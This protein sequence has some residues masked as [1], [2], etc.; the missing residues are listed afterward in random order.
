[1]K[2]NRVIMIPAPPRANWMGIDANPATP[3]SCRLARILALSSARSTVSKSS[4]SNATVIG[5]T[6]VV[7]VTVVVVDVHTP[8]ASGHSRRYEPLRTPLHKL[9]GMRAQL[10]TRL[11]H[12]GRVNAVR[13]VVV[14]VSVV[15]VIVVAVVVDVVVV[16]VVVVVVA[17][18]VF[19]VVVVTVHLY[20]H[21]F[22]Q[23]SASRVLPL[24]G[25]G[26]KQFSAGFERSPHSWGS[27]M[28]LHNGRVVLV[29][30]VLEAV[31]VVVMVVAV[32][33]V[34]VAVL[35]VVVVDVVVVVVVT[36][37]AVVAVVVSA[38][39]QTPQST[40]QRERIMSFVVGKLQ[41]DK[42]DGPSAV[43][44]LE[45]THV[46]VPS[47]VGTAAISRHARTPTVTWM[48][49][50]IAIAIAIVLF[51]RTHSC[52]NTCS[53]AQHVLLVSYGLACALGIL[54]GAQCYQQEVGRV[55]EAATVNGAC[56]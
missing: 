56:V 17:V 4:L 48:G 22:G 3:I 15:A 19:V 6:V 7:V 24:I 2:G 49:L 28:L 20:W 29:M 11:L 36:V 26:S 25:V 51:V 21:V 14:T 45:S 13:V 33:V 42:P 30:V 35:V 18:V 39:T 10:S 40:G 31:V 32:V 38:G 1:M 55:V 27:S 12:A 41:N 43:H 52:T 54:A 53:K 34:F 8:H 44:S 46:S 5:S 9:V 16:V 23:N 50:A 47:I 37:V